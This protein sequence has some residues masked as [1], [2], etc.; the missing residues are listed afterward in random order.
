MC[1]TGYTTQEKQENMKQ[2]LREKC[3]I[4]IDDPEKQETENQLIKK[5]SNEL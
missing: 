2:R 5:Q 4:I 1:K 3:L